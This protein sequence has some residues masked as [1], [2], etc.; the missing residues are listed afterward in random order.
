MVNT[1]LH[2]V[3]LFI[4]YIRL[5]VTLIYGKLQSAALYCHAVR[6]VLWIVEYCSAVYDHRVRMLSI[7]AVLRLNEFELR[8]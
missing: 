2:C 8:I 7:T 6:C 4:Q 1:G 5:V 3:Q